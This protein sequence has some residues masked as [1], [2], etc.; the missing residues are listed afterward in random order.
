[1]DREAERKEIYK[2]VKGVR[3]SRIE[4][5]VYLYLVYGEWERIA[6]IARYVYGEYRGD[7][8]IYYIRRVVPKLRK[9]LSLYGIEIKSNR[10]LRAYRI[11]LSNVE[12]TK[13]SD[14]NERIKRLKRKGKRMEIRVI[15]SNNEIINLSKLS[16]KRMGKSIVGIDSENNVVQVERYGSDKEAEDIM[17]HCFIDR[18]IVGKAEKSITDMLLIDLRGTKGV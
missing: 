2:R 9:K 17:E 5:R 18:L 7:N 3:L 11:K 14:I 1:M 8:E 6:D 16:I 15:N 12:E 13:E 10:G 4:R